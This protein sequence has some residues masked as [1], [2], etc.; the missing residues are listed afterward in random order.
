MSGTPSAD[1]SINQAHSH[2]GSLGRTRSSAT[3]G[4]SSPGSPAAGLR[5]FSANEEKAK[6]RTSDGAQLIDVNL[7]EPGDVVSFG[8]NTFSQLGLGHQHSVPVPYVIPVLA[9]R[10]IVHVTAGTLHAVALTEEGSVFTWG[11]SAQGQC[12]HQGASI[13]LNYSS[14]RR[15]AGLA[16]DR[17]C[18]IQ[19]GS[20]FTM[21]ISL[22][23]CVWAF[24]ANDQHQLGL[25][26]D[27][28]GNQWAPQIVPK[29]TG[30]GVVKISCSKRPGDAVGSVHCLALTARGEVYSW[31][32]G[33]TGQLG[34]GDRKNVE[35][36][37]L[38][39]ALSGIKVLDISC[40]FEHSA[41]LARR[42][43][44]T[45]VYAWGDNSRGQLGIGSRSLQRLPAEMVG[46]E[47]VSVA[48]VKCGTLCTG[49]LSDDGSLFMTGSGS[50]F[51]LGT[52]TSH[53]ELRPVR[54]AV[55][56]PG[57]AP[58]RYLSFG[59]EHAMA[60]DE[61]GGLWVWGENEHGQLGDAD[62]KRYRRPTRP[63]HF[64][65]VSVQT[66]ACGGY[67]SMVAMGS[68][69]YGA[70]EEG[71]GRRSWAE[72]LSAGGMFRTQR[73]R[74]AG[75][76]G[77]AIDKTDPTEE[78]APEAAAAVRPADV[79]LGMS[80]ASRL[81]KHFRDR[82]WKDDVIDA[83]E[84]YRPTKKMV[85]GYTKW[86]LQTCAGIGALIAIDK[87]IDA[88]FNAIGIKFPSNV[89]A[90]LA[91]FIFL[92]GISFLRLRPIKITIK[93]QMAKDPMKAADEEE[94]EREFALF[95]LG[96]MDKVEPKAPPPLALP[97]AVE[98]KTGGIADPPGAV[99][100]A[101]DGNGK[102]QLASGAPGGAAAGAALRR[103]ASTQAAAASAA[104][105]A[106]WRTLDTHIVKFM[107]PALAF[108]GK[109]FPF[110][111]TTPVVRLPLSA[112]PQGAE[113]AKVIFNN[114]LGWI[115]ALLGSAYLVIWMNKILKLPMPSNL[116]ASGSPKVDPMYPILWGVGALIS[117]LA[118]QSMDINGEY[119]ARMLCF[120]H[121]CV[122]CCMYCLGFMFWTCT[123]RPP[124]SDVIQVMHPLATAS[125][126]TC[127]I[128]GF[129]F[130]GTNG[131]FNEEAL[132]RYRV[133]ETLGWNNPRSPGAGDLAQELLA[134]AIMSLSFKL[135]SSRML[136]RQHWMDMGLMIVLA[137]VCGLFYSAAIAALFSIGPQFGKPIILRVIAAPAA[138]PTAR[139]LGLDV[140]ITSTLIV[141][142]GIIGAAVNLKIFNLLRINNVV[143]RGVAVGVACQGLGTSA[144]MADS[145]T[146]AGIAAVTFALIAVLSVIIVSIPP[147]WE[148]LVSIAS[149]TYS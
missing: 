101:A 111:Y 119:G 125:T 72:R 70:A 65:T 130:P 140:S 59:L 139:T 28:S 132:K 144:L 77:V 33:G 15:V 22:S 51:V 55:G 17:V 16:H 41:A 31:G 118:V 63:S 47:G 143:A 58:V 108:L 149:R 95:K 36:P 48:Y 11:D 89:A 99:A 9:T 39:E 135:F 73:D 103:T 14:P 4:L 10:R 148:A 24:G 105:A 91:I 134:P 92:I 94:E 127:I 96:K 84:E 145:P 80:D 133:L 85:V 69:D 62:A 37:T 116:S 76:L 43:T 35:E 50:S 38:V 19:A 45:V 87:A 90:L 75:R 60:V 114:L 142:N 29:L 137:S 40:G 78:P 56:G 74:I 93:V 110:F 6:S 8:A 1:P 71:L 100:V 68:P 12:G 120:Y 53:D 112:I 121:L 3:P 13:S 146:A 102:E 131:R 79:Q 46:L 2:A 7:A 18:Y 88:V 123:K 30:K 124:W 147:A 49:L 141:V 106:G 83:L 64:A 5:R 44:G 61:K 115:T 26:S 129:T 34:H 113:F 98:M 42:A 21:C 54:V 126:M 67:F 138:I 20:F 57:E 109:W 128:I 52:G 97:P 104:Q 32:S 23:G 82:S 25:G 86:L 136:L 27:K 122:L 107:T 81:R 117:G 66:V